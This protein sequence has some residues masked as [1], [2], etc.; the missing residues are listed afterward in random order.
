MVAKEFSMSPIVGATENDLLKE[1]KNIVPK[2]SNDRHKGQAG[3][4]GIIGGSKEYP[5][6]ILFP[7]VSTNL[8]V[9]IFV[10]F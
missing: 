5:G 10:C 8:C 1:V 3:R 6:T 7:I 9:L 4:I 2:L